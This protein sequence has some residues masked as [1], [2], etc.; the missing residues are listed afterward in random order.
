LEL[1]NSEENDNNKV[2][3]STVDVNGDM[4]PMFGS[5]SSLSYGGPPRVRAREVET[6]GSVAMV[7]T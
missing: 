7:A 1:L 2:A 6:L 4:H 5:R 3:K